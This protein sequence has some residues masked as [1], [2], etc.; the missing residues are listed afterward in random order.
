MLW[1]DVSDKV[2]VTNSYWKACTALRIGAKGTIDEIIDN[3]KAWLVNHTDWL[4]VLDGAD[5]LVSETREGIDI[6]HLLPPAGHG[7]II[8]TTHA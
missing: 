3:I 4:L 1:F 2:A 7:S 6:N 5:N 8:I